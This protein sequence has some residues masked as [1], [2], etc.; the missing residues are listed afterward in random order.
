MNQ[1]NW[2]SQP[3]TP[4]FPQISQADRAF[5]ADSKELIF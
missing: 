1:E 5:R 3:T 2:K 4:D